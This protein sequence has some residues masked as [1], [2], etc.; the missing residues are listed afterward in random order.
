MVDGQMGKSRTEEK[1]LCCLPPFAFLL[2]EDREREREK[3]TFSS[4]P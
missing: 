3:D 4:L 1:H 2:Y